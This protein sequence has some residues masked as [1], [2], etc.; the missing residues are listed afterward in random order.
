[1][2]CVIKERDEL[3]TVT[4]QP[5]A[6]LTWII[7]GSPRTVDYGQ[8][9]TPPTNPLSLSVSKGSYFAYGY[10]FDAQSTIQNP[11]QALQLSV[12]EATEE[13][14][15]ALNASVSMVEPSP[16]PTSPPLSDDDDYLFSMIGT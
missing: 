5:N 16:H 7:N 15:A 10:C 12:A 6:P 8:L 4:L 3:S 2:K 1:M 9:L 14:M 11:F 13:M